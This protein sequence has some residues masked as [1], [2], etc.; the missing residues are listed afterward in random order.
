[1]ATK[2]MESAWFQTP[3]EL[4][5]KISTHWRPLPPTQI[6]LKLVQPG[7]VLTQISFPFRLAKSLPTAKTSQ[8]L[9]L[10]HDSLNKTLP[11]KHLDARLLEGVQMKNFTRVTRTIF[12]QKL[13]KLTDSYYC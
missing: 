10:T 3:V 7:V 2:S 11:A 12:V 1:M 5:Y 13:S 4:Y 6:S 9:I 8:K